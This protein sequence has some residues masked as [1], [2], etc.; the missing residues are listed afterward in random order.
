M[1]VYTL[2]TS[3]CRIKTAASIKLTGNES[4]AWSHPDCCIN[5]FTNLREHLSHP[6]KKTELN[7]SAN[8]FLDNLVSA[9]GGGHAAEQGLSDGQTGPGHFHLS[10]LLTMIK[11]IE[12]HETK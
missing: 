1:Y 2:Y 9:G 5:Y 12:I 4:A 10:G 7:R 8:T 6:Q 3:I 11:S